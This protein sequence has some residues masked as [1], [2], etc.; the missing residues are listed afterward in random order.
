[1]TT[2]LRAQP[3]PKTAYV[4]DEAYGPTIVGRIY[5]FADPAVERRYL[6]DMAPHAQRRLTSLV[7]IALAV[8]VLRILGSGVGL[9]N[10]PDLP[11]VFAPRIAH[12]AIC[13]AVLLTLR[14]PRDYLFIE[15]VSFGFTVTYL[16]LRCWLLPGISNDGS[17]AV[18][19]GTISL[20]YFGSP[21][22]ITILAPV[23][24][25][26]SL[27]MLS[28]WSFS[29]PAPSF[30]ARFQVFE[31]IVVVNLL[32]IFSMLLMR[33][34]LRRQWA[35]SQALRHLATHDG[36]TG[37]ANRR[38]YDE[39][40]ARE[41]TRCRKDCADLSLVLMDVDFF[42]LLNDG[43]GHFA[44]DECLKA[45]SAL[46]QKCVQVPGALVARTGGEEFACVLPG[47]GQDQALEVAE[48]IA[49]SLRGE[50][51]PHPGSPIGPHVT[52]SLGVAT[53]RPSEGCTLRELTSLADRLVYAA[54]ND[55]RDCIRH[56]FLACE[57]LQIAAE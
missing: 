42:K 24:I 16:G 17:A 39:V 29:S 26:G 45:L 35:L 57:R 52:I 27:A 46:L 54:K 6:A 36:L 55:G 3:Q 11:S 47:I 48:R 8:T 31:W 12:L 43:V 21:L 18:I 49:G 14:K 19:I 7:W 56:Q 53:V 13:G 10:D 38:H 9:F 50:C 41:W 23:M 30:V 34:T 51:M 5:R 32:G 2:R 37:I 33:C 4:A 20:L 25:A 44:G 22:R 40:L 15:S 1:M 28:A